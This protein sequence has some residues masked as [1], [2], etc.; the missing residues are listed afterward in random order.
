VHS[1]LKL[2]VAGPSGDLHY[3]MRFN[4]S[5]PQRSSVESDALWD[6]LFPEKKGFVQHPELAP[7]VA[8]I[9]V[10]HELHCLVSIESFE[11]RL[12]LGG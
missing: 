12:W 11:N 9:A 5:Y 7:N 4:G 8:N 3:Y 6:S 1:K 10:F 2:F